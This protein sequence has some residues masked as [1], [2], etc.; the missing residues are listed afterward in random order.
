MASRVWCLIKKKGAGFFMIFW[1]NGLQNMQRNKQVALHCKVVY[2]VQSE[3]QWFCLPTTCILFLKL[4]FNLK[5]M[6]SFIT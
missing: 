1:L 2:V 4:M 5:N 6:N 3:T